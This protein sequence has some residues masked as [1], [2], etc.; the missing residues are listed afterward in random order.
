[1][2]ERPELENFVRDGRLRRGWSQDELARRSGLSRAGVSAIETNRLVPS[3]AAALALASAFGCRVEDLF[4]LPSDGAEGAAWAWPPARIPCRYWTARFPG[5]VRLFPF[6]PTPL[7]VVPH[8]GVFNGGPVPGPGGS[9]ADRTLVLACCDPAVGLLAGELARAADVRL[10]VLPRPSRESLALLG[11]GSVHAAGIHLSAAGRPDGNAEV[12]R[13]ALGPGYALLRVARWEEGIA[14][15][16]GLRLET[17]GA[18]VRSKLRWVGREPGSGARQ[19][20]DEI[21]EGPTPRRLALDHRGV[22]DAVRQGWADAGVC[23]RLVSE[24]AGLGFLGVREEVYDLCL[25]AT[26]KGDH[27][28]RALVNAVRSAPYRRLLG[29]LPGYDAADA[30]ELD[31]V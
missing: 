5:G 2:A 26:W 11:S 10:I 29:E 24:E 23:L 22:A 4:H 21:L 1:M 7:G 30:G 19:C 31:R 8:D 17:V 25:P 14:F 27:R 18:A 6:E 3:T 13:A 15:S 9:E 16:P 12:V 28:L 20:Q